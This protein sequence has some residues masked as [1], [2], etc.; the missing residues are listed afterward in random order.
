MRKISAAGFVGQILRRKM[1]RELCSF[2]AIGA[3]IFSGIS[4]GKYESPTSHYD[5]WPQLMKDGATS[6]GWIASF[7]PNS[8]TNISERHDL[9]SNAGCFRFFA[10][11]ADLELLVSQLE[12]V[13][14][15]RFDSIGPWLNGSPDWWPPALAKKRLGELVINDGF[16]IYQ[17]VDSVSQPGDTAVWYFAINPPKGIGYGWHKGN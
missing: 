8:S 7:L 10:P 14:S 11:T 3:V 13:P 15:S 9:D 4:C 5:T 6:R 17:K 2:A 1:L 16:E 12:R